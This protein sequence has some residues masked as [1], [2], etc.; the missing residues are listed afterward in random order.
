MP[1]KI[2]VDV[3]G[4]TKLIAAVHSSTT[5]GSSFRTVSLAKTI[6]DV[7]GGGVEHAI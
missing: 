5:L 4:G 7:S 1:R 6:Q 3:C 2:V